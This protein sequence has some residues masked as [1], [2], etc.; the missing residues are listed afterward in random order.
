MGDLKS[1]LVSDTFARH[2]RMEASAYTI[3]AQA[4]CLAAA[5]HTETSCALWICI[6]V[7]AVWPVADLT[8]LC[9]FSELRLRRLPRSLMADLLGACWSGVGEQPVRPDGY[10]GL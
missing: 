3:S 6:R 7:Q 8:A 2:L 4:A 5:T 10:Q 9:N 1:A